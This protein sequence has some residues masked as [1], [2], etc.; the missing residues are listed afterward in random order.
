MFIQSEVPIQPTDTAVEEVVNLLK[1]IEPL[2]PSKVG[3]LVEKNIFF[4]EC[5]LE[6][7]VDSFAKSSLLDFLSIIR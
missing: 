4:R 3:K 2:C 7:V 1:E 6:L 5:F